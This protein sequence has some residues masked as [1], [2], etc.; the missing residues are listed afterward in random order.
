MINRSRATETDMRRSNSISFDQT[1]EHFRARGFMRVPSA[2]SG[3]EAEAMRAAVWRVLER[4]KIRECEPST[5]T[6]ERPTYRGLG[7]A[8]PA[9]DWTDFGE[10]LMARSQE[11][12]WILHHFPERKRMERAVERLACRFA[13]YK[14]AC[15]AG[16]HQVA[17]V[18]GRR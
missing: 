16:R 9:D 15:A 2:F 1:L 6:T 13:L 11:L 7:T 3:Y 18:N 12:G 4:S 17:C 14:C 5:W 10:R 8:Y